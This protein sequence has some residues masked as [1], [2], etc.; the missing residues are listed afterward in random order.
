MLK[1]LVKHEFSA[2]ARIFAPLFGV[3]MALCGLA[4]LAIRLGGILVLSGGSGLGSPLFGVLSAILLLFAILALFALRVAVVVITVQRFYKNLLGGEGYLMF[5][6]PVTP[7]Q[8]I[9]AK[10][11]VG[12][13]WTA[14]AAL[15]AFAALLAMVSAVPGAAENGLS[16]RG[17]AALLFQA[18][19]IPAGLFLP[20]LFATFLIA[21]SNSYLLA[22]LSMA[23]GS[24]WQG[25]RLLASFAA[26][27]ALQALLSVLYFVFIFFGAGVIAALHW[28]EAAVRFIESLPPLSVLCLF[29]GGS[30]C[31]LLAG[32]AIY[33]C[34]TRHLLTKRLNLA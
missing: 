2:T 22:Y 32:D 1:K 11:A 5:T 3:A 34:V 33:Y 10:L 9:L 21:A 14:A 29:L 15:F 31:I 26:Y 28:E 16:P 30:S 8:H 24:Q 23:I 20:I 7:G 19:G 6:L 4:V 18:S 25:A 12:M 17:F 13:T 27:A